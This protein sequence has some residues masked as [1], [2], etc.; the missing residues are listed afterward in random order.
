MIITGLE[1][2]ANFPTFAANTSDMALELNFEALKQISIEAGK[3]ILEIYDRDDFESITDFKA[4]NS[5]LTLADKA[6]H[7]VIERELKVL[8]PNIPILSEEG[9]S[10][11]FEERKDWSRFWLVDPLDGT[12]E[13]IKR[14]GEF[15]VNIALIENGSPVFGVVHVP[16]KGITYWNEDESHAYKQTGKAE[17]ETISVS[18]FSEKD[19]GLRFVCSR[20][21][22]SPE[23]EEYIGK[24]KEPEKVSMGSSLKFMIL[25]EGGAE[26]Y[27]RLGL[28]SEWD[29]AAAQAVLEAAGGEVVTWPELKPMQYNKENILN[30]YFIAR[31]KVMPV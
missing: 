31:G 16:V 14:N 9:N 26:I 3:V 24:Y 17:I 7:A 20:S 13:F 27:P 15:T 21:H 11:S 28:T 23:I 12:K 22:L 30:P 5:P 6:A 8:Y 19:A 29:T 18:H 10:I 25:A 2:E 1:S 4:D